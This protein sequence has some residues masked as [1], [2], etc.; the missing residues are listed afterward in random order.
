MAAALGA[1]IDLLHAL[2][3]AAW[4]LGLPLL[5]WH[6]W[7]R[8]TTR[9]AAYAIAFIVANQ[10]SSYLLGECFLTSLARACWQRAGAV[11]SGEWFTVR[12]AEAVFRLTP[13][14]RSVRLSSEALIL[15]T[16]AGVAFRG[17]A[18]RRQR[19]PKTSSIS[20]KHRDEAH[21]AQILP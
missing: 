13:S 5:F 14:H 12:L 20:R 8:L 10:V 3:M 1:G 6:R 15:V 4:M 16:A 2:L 21:V 7:P 18:P 19:G 17:L 11:P 9:Y